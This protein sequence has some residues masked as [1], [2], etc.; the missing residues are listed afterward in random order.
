MA[1]S[2]A[3]C[4]DGA[5]FR[6]SDRTLGAAHGIPNAIAQLA[7]AVLRHQP[8][9]LVGAVRAIGE[10]WGSSMNQLAHGKFVAH[11]NLLG[12]KAKSRSRGAALQAALNAQPDSTGITPSECC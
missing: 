4:T 2:G 7:A 3:S 10:M 12:Q 9:N 5:D 11:E 8:N 6:F 1:L